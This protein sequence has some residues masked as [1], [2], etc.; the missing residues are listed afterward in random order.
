MARLYLALVHHPV[1]DRNGR[2][3][4]SAITSLDLHDIARSSRT[5]GVRGFFVVHPIPEQREFAATVLDHWRVNFGRAFDGRR[6]EAL[7]LVRIVDRLDHAIEV[8]DAETGSRPLLIHTSAQ[9]VGGIPHAELRARLDAPEAPPAILLLGTGFGLAPEVRARAD[10]LAA[11]I[12]GADSYNHLS[13]RAAAAILLD[14][15][16]G[17]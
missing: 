9:T 10:L 15:L 8:V 3:V 4:T 13:V 14:R 6:R 7:E 1:L 16:C 17:A 2:I 11:P 5:Y 12:L